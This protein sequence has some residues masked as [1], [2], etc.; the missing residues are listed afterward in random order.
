MWG[1][2]NRI[3]ILQMDFLIIVFCNPFNDIFVF[4]ANCAEVCPVDFIVK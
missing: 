2:H 3:L 1:L 4:E